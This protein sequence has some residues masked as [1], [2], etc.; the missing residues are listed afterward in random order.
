M[1]SCPCG[2]EKKFAECC[3][4]YIIGKKL[5]PTAEALMRARY[6]AYVEHNIDYIEATHSKSK[7]DNLSIE[8]TRKWAEESIWLG[9]EILKV[10]KG[11]ETDS[12]GKVEFIAR[13]NQEKMTYEHHE[14]SRFIKEDGEWFYLAG[15]V[16]NESKAATSKKEIR[17]ND[18]C[19]CGSGK[20]YKKCCAVN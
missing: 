10:Q 20:K 16:S 3:E 9:L 6:C 4:P 7:R 19:N 5:A 18:P 8:E 11:T 2:T 12:E 15:Q 17:R 14:L 13:F 1:K